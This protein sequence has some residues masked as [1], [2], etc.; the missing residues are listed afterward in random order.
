MEQ[1]LILN[2][3]YEPINIIPWK[4]AIRLLCQEKVEVLAEYDK[5]I[6]SISFTIR[7]PS[8]LRLLKS[9]KIRKHSQKVKFCRSNIYARDHH[10]CQYCGNKCSTT[11]LTFDHVVPIVKGGTKTWRNIVTCCFACNHKKGGH[12]PEEAG[13]RLIR[14]P[15]E[16]EWI[17]AI[18]HITIGLRTAPQ[19]WRDYLY[20]NIEL[21]SEA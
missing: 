1:T 4:R 6:R 13:M 8:V 5:E 17:P 7:M 19:A 20:W 18:L 3:T 2:A 9:V 14:Q 21:E 16:P 15:R 10:T 11:N 12:T